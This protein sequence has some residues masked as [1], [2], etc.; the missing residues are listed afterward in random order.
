MLTLFVCDGT[1]C[2]IS[3]TADETA[4]PAESISAV[5]NV[6]KAYIATFMGDADV[7]LVGGGGGSGSIF[8]ATEDQAIISQFNLDDGSVGSFLGGALV[9]AITP[10]VTAYIFLVLHQ[11]WLRQ[12]V[13]EKSRPAAAVAGQEPPAEAKGWRRALMS[14]S[15]RKMIAALL[16]GLAVAAFV[17]SVPILALGDGDPE[18]LPGFAEEIT[19]A[20]SGCING[21]TTEEYLD[22]APIASASRVLRATLMTKAVRVRD[23]AV[24]QKTG[25]EYLVTC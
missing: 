13:T 5:L 11:A 22:A 8:S 12:R 2:D 23:V 24:E 1:S 14:A 21:I 6:D 10:F 17:V 9:T 16:A 18:I 25:L 20:C 19:S 15:A 3:T 7:D 4:F